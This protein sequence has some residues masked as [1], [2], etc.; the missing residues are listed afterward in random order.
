[1]WGSQLHPF[2]VLNGTQL[3]PR[4]WQIGDG[5]GDG[6]PIPGKSGMGMGMDPRSPANRGWTPIPI[7]GQ[8]GDGDGDGD[9]GFRALVTHG[10]RPGNPQ[11]PFSRFPIWPGNGRG[12]EPPIPDSAGLGIGKQ[13]EGIP[14]V[15]RFGRRVYTGNGNRGPDSAGRGFPGDLVCLA[16]MVLDFR[17]VMNLT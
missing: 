13:P 17:R 16:L 5:D 10:P 8:I 2:A 14:A 9:R 12:R 7:P 15:S 6:P 4:F 3:D 11:F 1:M